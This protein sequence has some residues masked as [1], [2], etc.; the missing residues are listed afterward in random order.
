MVK[1]SIIFGFRNKEIDRVETCLRSLASQSFKDFEVVFVD[2]G[3]DTSFSEPLK[4]M[5]SAFSFVTYVYSNTK[6]MPWNRSHAFNTGI[7]MAKGEFVFTSDVDLVF[8]KDCLQT[9]C[10]AVNGNKA[11]F[12]DVYLMNKG[13]TFKEGMSVEGIKV[14]RGGSG[15]G[16]YPTAKLQEI[17]GYDEYFKIWGCEDRDLKQRLE[18]A[19][20]AI[21]VMDITK[22]PIFH[23]W[24]PQSNLQRNFLPTGWWEEMN[25]YLFDNKKRVD[26]NG[27]NWGYVY[28]DADRPSLNCLEKGKVSVELSG[29]EH[30]SIIVL[31][32]KVS[33]AFKEMKSGDSLKVSS[34]KNVQTAD[35][36]SAL[37]DSFVLKA[38]N[39]I[40]YGIDKNFNVLDFNKLN[41]GMKMLKDAKL[42]ES[43]IENLKN[44]SWLF[45]QKY[46]SEI[47]DY[48]FAEYKGNFV[49]ILVRN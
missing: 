19:G 3:S 20:L 15:M 25:L 39:K 21:E 47:K 28:T 11:V 1:L 48:Y 26:R 29:D 16:I 38:L 9:F 31:F 41:N 40:V 12:S 18:L 13:Q 46:K 14:Q 49:C 6:G 30:S 37:P 27:T 5:L 8:S 43:D 45:I 22:A 7:R 24:H 36:K 17:G 42:Y 2:Y 34:G 33:D 32:E 4:K 10:N 35:V 23:Q 44:F